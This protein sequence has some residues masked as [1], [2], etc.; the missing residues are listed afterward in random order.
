MKKHLLQLIN[1]LGGLLPKRLQRLIADFPGVLYL[2]QRLGRNAHE[3]LTTPEGFQLDLNP[4]F[5]SN[6]ISKGSLEGY[7]PEM[8][9]AIQLATKPGQCAYDVGANV[10]VFSYLF[11]S[12]VGSTGRVYAFEPEPNNFNCLA[13]SVELN[14]TDNVILDTRALGAVNRTELFD[15]RGGAF[16]GRLVG[17]DS[18]H[19]PTKNLIKVE[20]TSIDS[21]IAQENY[22]APDV[23]KIDVEGNEKLVLEGMD[24]T[25]RRNKPII[26]CELH[27][28]LGDA[29][30][31]VFDL[32]KSYKYDIFSISD[33]IVSGQDAI[34]LASLGGVR[35]I[36]AVS[37][38]G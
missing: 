18:S 36:V 25:L 35:H 10:G 6:L 2:L 29:V 21:L 16:S 5:H 37:S 22:T 23:I 31:D 11:A 30:E 26:I 13:R 17:A 7:E 15:R 28:H 33:F 1:F 12:L 32:L 34:P 9:R 3:V 27:G 24:E 4:L 38:N 19:K 20:T 14:A 8:R